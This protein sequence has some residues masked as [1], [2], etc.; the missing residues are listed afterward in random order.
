LKEWV[1]NHVATDIMSDE[2]LA[3]YN[4]EMVSQKE[5]DRARAKEAASAAMEA[6][7]AAK[8][9]AAVAILAAPKAEENG[10]DN[11]KPAENEG[12]DQEMRDAEGSEQAH[13]TSAA[14]VKAEHVAEE[15][16]GK[17]DSEATAAASGMAPDANGHAATG[18]EDSTGQDEAGTSADQ[19]AAA[20]PTTA[21]AEGDT[22]TAA[23]A[24]PVDDASAEETSAVELEEGPITVTEDE[25]K[26][27]WLQVGFP[28][29][30]L[31]GPHHISG[32]SCCNLSILIALSQLLLLASK[33][34][35][36]AM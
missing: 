25:V 19:P 9:A 11:S 15:A 3:A 20:E 6:A 14:A 24:G 34:T 16:G 26:Q 8:A 7:A 33:A 12:G 31:L 23:A 4:A 21:A 29:L 17:P 30:E 13:E 36:K 32:S 28:R 2:E 5:A 22:A 27:A 35:I 18:M 10:E 1:S